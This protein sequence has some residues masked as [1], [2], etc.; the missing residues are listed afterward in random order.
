MLSPLQHGEKFICYC[1]GKGEPGCGRWHPLCRASLSCRG[2]NMGTGQENPQGWGHT[3]YGKR[4]ISAFYIRHQK[5]AD[6]RLQSDYKNWTGQYHQSRPVLCGDWKRVLAVRFIMS[7]QELGQW[8]PLTGDRAG[9]LFSG[10]SRTGWHDSQ[11]QAWEWESTTLQIFQE[12]DHAR[13]PITDRAHLHCIWTGE[14]K[15]PFG[16]RRGNGN[17]VIVA[18]AEPWGR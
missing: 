13:R 16:C 14:R 2:W 17:H 4:R 8:E 12:T 3:N 6:Y 5:P 10:S 1:R 15:A 11:P 7:D 9:W 18:Y